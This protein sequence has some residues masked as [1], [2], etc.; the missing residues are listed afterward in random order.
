MRVSRTTCPHC[1]RPQFFP[2]VDIANSQLEQDKVDLRLENVRQECANNGCLDQFDLFLKLTSSADAIFAC[3]LEKL[4]REIASGTELFETFY[5][6]ERLRLRASTPRDLNW[7]KLRP[8]AEI[9]LLGSHDH[10]DKLHYA[11]LSLDWESLSN[12]GD[13]VVKLSESMISHRA[14]C[15]EGNTAIV[16]AFEHDFSQYLRCS[17]SVRG[18]IAAATMG[19]K[20]TTESKETEF[21]QIL[22]LTGASSLEDEFVEV[23]IFGPMTARTFEEVRF[24]TDNHKPSDAVYLEA[25]KEKLS[26]ASV[27]IGEDI[28]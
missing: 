3:P 2:N 17:W 7:R 26:N 15:F 16:Y 6:L 28:Q 19:A 4:H 14:T 12:Y 13:C 20:L 22:V 24:K 5:D 21:P 1:G 9:E 25:I 8:Q 18:K 10:L 23:H 27:V 11:S